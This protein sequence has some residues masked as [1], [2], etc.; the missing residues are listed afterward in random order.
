M[1]SDSHEWK[2][3]L[4]LRSMGRAQRIPVGTFGQTSLISSSCGEAQKSPD[5]EVPPGHAE[6]VHFE[7]FCRKLGCPIDYLKPG[8]H[9]EAK[10]HFFGKLA[11]QNCPNPIMANGSPR[12]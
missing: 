12:V 5:C 3:A 6:H 11:D 1:P 4:S 7:A 2:S 9:H 10:N 8:Q